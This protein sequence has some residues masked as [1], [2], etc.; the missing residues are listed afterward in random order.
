MTTTIKVTN[1]LRDRLKVQARRSGRTLGE[2]LAVLA[3]ES[4]RADRFATLAA[5]MS[6]TPAAVREV[7]EAETAEWERTELT[8][9]NWPY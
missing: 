6:R 2:H 1:E 3:D 8:G 5:T 9:A 7:Y 4:D